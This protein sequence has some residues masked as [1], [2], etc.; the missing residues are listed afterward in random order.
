MKTKMKL[1]VSIALLMLM[2]VVLCSCTAVQVSASLVMNSDGSGSREIV[3]SIA[4]NDYQDGYGSAYY[5]F[6]KHGDDLQTYLTD[7]YTALVPG[8]GEWL[9]IT[10]DDGGSDWEIITLRFDFTSFDDYLTKL[11]SLVYDETQTSSYTAPELKTG[12]DGML[13]YTESTSVLT[14][15]F[16]SLQNTVMAD[17]TIFDINCTKDGTALND[18]SANDYLADYG[19]E[20]MKPE[21]GNAMTVSFDGSDPM[22]VEAVDGV[23]TVS[24]GQGSGSDAPEEADKELVLDYSFDETLD[25]QGTMEDGNLLFGI[26]STG[27]NPVYVDG[28]DGKAVLFD[29][30]TYLASSNKSFNF[31]ELTVSFYYRMDQYTETDTGANMVLVP[32]GLGALGSGV[33]DIEFIR[34]ADA[35]GIQILGKMNSSDW[36]TQDK[37]YSEGYYLD[38]H[39]GE[40]HNYTFVYMNEYDDEGYIEDAY[41]YIYI[42]GK[43]AARAR[44]AVAAGLT[45]SLG[46]YDDGS[47]GEPN[48]GFNV[49]GYY[50]AETVKRGLTG[51]LD[52][53]KIFN[54]ALDADEVKALCYTTAVEKEYDPDSEETAGNESVETKPEETPDNDT[55]PAEE[56][57]NTED[58][59]EK[60]PG[61]LIP[62]V[63]AAVL[64]V[65]AG[66]A[67]VAM[68]KKKNQ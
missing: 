59:S 39:I 29:G 66:S 20:L 44:L 16:K 58:D 46:M 3:G 35:D 52:N 31:S 50:E 41:T 13:T 67:A 2:V 8:S 40:W 38:N 23:Y 36:Q 21:N 55:I 51:A 15:V 27:E 57:K 19:V 4:K 62:T 26:G 30:A 61:W 7:V 53:L 28:V 68:K 25:N 56:T 34:E 43:L 9:D 47:F 54:G 5:Y 17:D 18:G 48:G 12:E 22:A 32:A 64:V 60:V 33:I 10:V 6:K 63:I 37:L 1:S 45:F 24:S 14:A 42:D 65:C 11:S 49:G